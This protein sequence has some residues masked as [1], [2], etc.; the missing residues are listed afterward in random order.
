M[1]SEANVIYPG[2]FNGYPNYDDI[3]NP[4]LR[5]WNRLNTVFNIKEFLKNDKMAANYV[6]QFP[7]EDQVAVA[8]MAMKVTRDGYENTRR[9]IMSKNN[10]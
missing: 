10:N 1:K 6:K 9:S 2:E 4:I 3:I 8:L 7:R 5:A